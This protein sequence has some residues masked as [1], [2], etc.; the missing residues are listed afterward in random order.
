M[1]S[2]AST[3]GAI[4]GMMRMLAAN[5]LLAAVRRG[6]KRSLAIGAAAGGNQC[7][8]SEVRKGINF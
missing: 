4:R 2:G 7:G 3:S 8:S 1:A 6:L 5:A